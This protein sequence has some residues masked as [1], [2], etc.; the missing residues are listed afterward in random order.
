MGYS[1]HDKA[2]RSPFYSAPGYFPPMGSA[3]K[4]NY[5]NY[6]QGSKMMKKPERYMDEGQPECEEQG[7]DFPGNMV[8]N[9]FSRQDREYPMEEEFLTNEEEDYEG[10]EFE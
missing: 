10:D 9:H 4:K 6:K 3:G 5:L 2:K 1:M 8:F 7:L